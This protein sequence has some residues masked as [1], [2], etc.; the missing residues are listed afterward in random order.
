ML[1]YK[2]LAGNEAT[3]PKWHHDDT[4]DCHRDAREITT[5]ED[6]ILEMSRCMR[7]RE[8]HQRHDDV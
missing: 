3:F 2:V 4:R 8:R 7:S 6:G 5:A 1:A